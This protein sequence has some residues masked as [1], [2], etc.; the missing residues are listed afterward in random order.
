[1]RVIKRRFVCFMPLT[2]KLFGHR[3]GGWGIGNGK[4]G[5]RQG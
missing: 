4:L 2:F 1:M 5:D 3:G